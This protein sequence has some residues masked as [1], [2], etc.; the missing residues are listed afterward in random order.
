M[1]GAV[2]LAVFAT[3]LTSDLVG[4]FLIIGLAAFGLLIM[5]MI[6]L[7]LVVHRV[8]AQSGVDSDKSK[9]I[10]Y[11]VVLAGL[12]FLIL[13]GGVFTYGWIQRG[14][15]GGPGAL[16]EQLAI[17]FFLTFS[18]MALLLA[19][20]MTAIFFSWAKLADQRQALG[21]PEGSVR[22]VIALALIIIFAITA[23]FFYSRVAS[24]AT[25][26]ST[27]LTEDEVRLI[28][29]SE[30]LSTTADPLP[31]VD[32]QAT[33][34]PSGAPTPAPVVQ[35]YTVT[36]IDPA[37]V[38]G[39]DL[40]QQIITT[41]STLVVAVSAFYFGTS[42]VKAAVEAVGSASSTDKGIRITRPKPPVF[43]RRTDDGW[44][45]VAI[46]VESVPSN[47]AIKG[48][49][50]TGDIDE[51]ALIQDEPGL[52]SYGPGNP[53]EKV[54][55]RFSLVGDP[56]TEAALILDRSDE[57]EPKGGVAVD[58]GGG[59]SALTEATPTTTEV[60]ADGTS[61]ISL[62]QPDAVRDDSEVVGVL[63]DLDDDEEADDVPDEDADLRDE[64]EGLAATTDDG[65]PDTDLGQGISNETASADAQ[66]HARAASKPDSQGAAAQPDSAT[67]VAPRVDP[68][69]QQP[70]EPGPA[71]PK[72]DPSSTSATRKA[73]TRK[74]LIDETRRGRKKTDFFTAD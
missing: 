73:Q 30:R 27:G 6:A 9:G 15:E 71:D 74:R 72:S 3:T 63:D 35:T 39:N 2:G 36:R 56:S 4:P 42:S 18:V 59:G 33:P 57:E 8:R 61:D 65:V 20:S 55:L 22:A 13:L 67:N 66:V 7:S 10:I 19:L 11:Y 12:P 38:Q 54:V 44:A 49:I 64:A 31:T 21:L 53:D 47:Q 37:Q 43:M 1:A 48:V 28:P 34:L 23:V 29:V 32:P 60:V 68:R 62:G 25:F 16:P 52:F 45:S 40:A 17:T 51:G 5:A 50:A 46:E 14:G 26:V 70:I 41:V 58:G 24:S 69:Q